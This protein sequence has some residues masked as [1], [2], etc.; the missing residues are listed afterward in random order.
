M[1]SALTR[2][3]SL[4]KEKTK[5]R[6]EEQLAKI[7]ENCYLFKDSSM[8]NNINNIYFCLPETYFVAVLNYVSN[9]IVKSHHL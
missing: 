6:E 2:K 4:P 5:K 9:S 3:H 1:L 8:N 7:K